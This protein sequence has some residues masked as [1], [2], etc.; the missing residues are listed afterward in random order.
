MKLL[1]INDKQGIYKT[2]LKL[3]GKA[4]PN[5]LINLPVNSSMIGFCN[6]RLFV[7]IVKA[8]CSPLPI[9]AVYPTISEN[10]MAEVGEIGAFAN[11]VYEKYCERYFN[12]PVNSSSS[13]K[14][15]AAGHPPG[16]SKGGRL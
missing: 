14:L 15:Y 16:F 9:N 10:M 13:K 11:L 12:L 4:S 1:Y 5:S 3:A 7:R 8:Y 6:Y 2:G